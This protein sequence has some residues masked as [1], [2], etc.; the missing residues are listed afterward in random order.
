[1][2]QATPTHGSAPDH[3][4]ALDL[5]WR[6]WLLA[7]T[8]ALLTLIFLALSLGYYHMHQAQSRLDLLAGQFLR[9]QEYTQQM[10]QSSQ[11]RTLLLQRML[12]T[13]DPFRRDEM[14]LMHYELATRFGEARQALLALDPGKEEVERLQRIT[15]LVEEVLPLQEEYLDLVDAERLQE[16]AVLLTHSLL[17]AQDRLLKALEDL[18]GQSRLALTA[19]Q[20]RL[21]GEMSQ[22]L[23]GYALLGVLI[24]LLAFWLALQVVRQTQEANR[25]RERLALHDPLT[26]LPNRQLLCDRIGL[27]QAHARRTHTLLGVLFVDLDRFKPVNDRLGHAAG[28]A[29]LRAVA[30]RLCATVRAK[31]TVARLGGDEFVVLAGDAARQ[32]DLVRVAEHIVDALERPFQVAGQEVQIGCSIGMSVYPKDAERPEE[33]LHCADL[34]MYRAKEA[35]RG[36]V[37]LYDPAME[38]EVARLLP[39]GQ[40][41]A[42]C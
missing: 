37:Y 32:E 2:S 33:L 23:W 3:H 8:G 31:D 18:A 11:R 35:G 38:Q 9:K 21:R 29:L 17:P 40:D 20:G 42:S 28:D 13:A 12:H 39:A 22:A 41:R 7:G 27:A 1:M 14:K 19:A 10:F 5:R 34:A 24:L 26:G 30:Q 6:H 16:A 25:L 15:A 36:Q 4:A